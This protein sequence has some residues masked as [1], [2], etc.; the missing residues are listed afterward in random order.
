MF[1]AAQHDEIGGGKGADFFARGVI[2]KGGGRK[3]GVGDKALRYGGDGRKSG[4]HKR[5]ERIQSG[6]HTEQYTRRGNGDFERK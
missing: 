3:V 2:Q 5:R 4:K 1:V 6:F